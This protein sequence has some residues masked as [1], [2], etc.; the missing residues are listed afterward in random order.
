MMNI[1]SNYGLNTQTNEQH[2]EEAM[3]HHKRDF[4]KRNG[5]SNAIESHPFNDW[6]LMQACK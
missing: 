2:H 6:S 1:K 5:L 3:G 4:R